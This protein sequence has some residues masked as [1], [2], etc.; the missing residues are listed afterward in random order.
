LK[1]GAGDHNC[2]HQD[3]YGDIHFPLQVIIQ[4]SQPGYDFK[5][6]ELVLVEQRPRMQSRPSVVNPGQGQAIVVPVKDRPY[7]GKRGWTR[8]QIRHG[9]SAVLSGTRQTLGIIF[10]DAS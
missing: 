10:H 5:G 8:T 7:Y 2:L 4:L 3:L 9:V 1:Y 6:G